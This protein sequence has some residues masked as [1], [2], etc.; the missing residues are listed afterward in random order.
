MGII[1]QRTAGRLDRLARDRGIRVII[2]ASAKPR[3]RWYSVGIM[4]GGRWHQVTGFTSAA[5]VE[6]YIA[7]YGPQQAGD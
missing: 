2:Q 4:S 1:N 3:R 7:Q 5:H 6:Q